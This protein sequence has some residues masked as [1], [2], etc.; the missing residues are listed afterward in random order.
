M[1]Q[2]EKRQYR[3]WTILLVAV[4]CLVLSV[5]YCFSQYQAVRQDAAQLV[6]QRV[7]AQR[8]LI[9]HW[10]QERFWTVKELSESE[11]VRSLDLARMEQAFGIKQKYDV[12]YDSLSFIDNDGVFRK[13]T[14]QGGIRFPSALGRPYFEKAMAGEDFISEVVLGRNSGRLIINFSSP[15]R[16]QAGQIRG[17][18]LGSIRT[19]TLTELFQGS[20]EGKT[21]QINLLNR[22]GL[23]LTEPR[24]SQ[25]LKARGY[26]WEAAAMNLKATDSLLVQMRPGGSGAVAWTDWAQTRVIGYYIAVPERGWTIVGRIDEAEAMAPFYR[27]MAIM[28]GGLLLLLLCVFPLSYKIDKIMTTLDENAARFETMMTQSKEA[29]ILSEAGAG[30]I[31]EVNA[32]AAD[33]FGYTKEEMLSMRAA[34]LEVSADKGSGESGHAGRI[35]S[36]TVTRRR[37]DGSVKFLEHAASLIRHQNQEMVLHTYRYLSEAR[38]LQEKV[39]KDISLAGNIQR[40]LIQGDFQNAHLTLRTLYYPS[41]YVSGDH[42]GY[43]WTADG[44][45]LNGFLLDVSGH[46]FAAAIQTAAIST[47]C[48]RLMAEQNSWSLAA[49]AKLNLQIPGYL[50]EDAFAGIFVFSLDV[51]QRMLT[52]ITG[53]INH[54]LASTTRQNGWV[55]LPGCYLGID[56]AAQFEQMSFKLQ[57]GDCFYFLT[58]GI[59]DRMNPSAPIDAGDFDATVG[60]LHEL[61]SDEAKRDDSTGLCLQF[62][63]ERLSGGDDYE[64]R[65]TACVD[66]SGRR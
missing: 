2:R 1:P 65:G 49:V 44:S 52:C 40:Q 31:V 60:M 30:R 56:K 13:S 6:Q 50:S 12:N 20:W 55:T 26:M 19:A 34:E 64:Y 38:K 14:L 61:A 35:H 24:H 47:L 11:A 28:A 59:T 41:Q 23:L 54:F 39:A 48:N 33:M 17:L 4:P 62:H 53:G 27:Q 66:S 58:D 22:Q 21:G 9:D 5:I 25:E 10:V 18:V 46:G 63:P 15:V 57:P 36:N 32:A 8:R 7:E 43:Q 51:R 3:L 37:K 42:Y 45:V 16:D 29:F